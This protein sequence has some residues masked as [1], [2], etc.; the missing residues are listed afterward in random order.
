MLVEEEAQLLMV[1]LLVL[2]EQ[3]AVALVVIQEALVAHQA[4]LT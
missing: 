3:V 4:L 2:A 1:G